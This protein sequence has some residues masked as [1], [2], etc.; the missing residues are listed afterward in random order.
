MNGSATYDFKIGEV[1]D[2]TRP[3]EFSVGMDDLEEATEFSVL[4]YW[5]LRMS[6]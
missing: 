2:V 3:T 5:G 6:L 1:L 4:P